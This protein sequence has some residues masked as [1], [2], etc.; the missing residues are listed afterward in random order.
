MRDA[1]T[2]I[3]NADGN[4]LALFAE[5][6]PDFG[7]VHQVDSIRHPLTGKWSEGVVAIAFTDQMP[8]R[9][10]FEQVPRWR[11]LAAVIV[12]W[13]HDHQMPWWIVGD[14]QHV[15]EL[16]DDAFFM[17][18]FVVEDFDRKE[19]GAF[20][21]M[22][23]DSCRC[24]VELLPAL[25]HPVRLAP[26][27]DALVALRQFPCGIARGCRSS[28]VLLFVCRG[29]SQSQGGSNGAKQEETVLHPR[30]LHG[31]GAILLSLIV[32]AGVVVT[33]IQSL[34]YNKP[35]NLWETGNAT[36]EVLRWLAAAAAAAAA[37]VIIAVAVAAIILLTT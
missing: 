8:I 3:N 12:R 28:Q 11:N 7:R 9:I 18:R 25:F 35:P 20:H 34:A 32:A 6:I 14:I 24:L 26:H 10:L 33:V 22:D 13:W 2:S 37:V 19:I 31:G 17:M 1:Q 23:D 36:T 16:T 4:A 30:H 27:D 5:C 15:F 21:L 29:D